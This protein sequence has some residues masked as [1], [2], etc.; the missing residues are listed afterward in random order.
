MQNQSYIDSLHSL[1]LTNNTRFTLLKNRSV[2]QDKPVKVYYAWALNPCDAFL[3]DNPLPFASY[4]LIL[5]QKPG[6]TAIAVG[7]I[8]STKST[9]GERI[10][11]FTCNKGFSD[12]AVLDFGIAALI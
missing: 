10:F 2:F 8:S 12:Y 9:P 3:Q 5:G 1:S 6:G 7:S 4:L 11:G